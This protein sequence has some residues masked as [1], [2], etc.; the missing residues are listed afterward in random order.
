MNCIHLIIKILQKVLKC[1][2]IVNIKSKRNYASCTHKFTIGERD[3]TL[4]E[5]LPCTRPAK[6]GSIP[7]IAY[8]APRT[9]Q[10]HL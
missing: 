2:L 6:L 8:I 4:G 9:A 7:G 1:L 5:V 3:S 10:S